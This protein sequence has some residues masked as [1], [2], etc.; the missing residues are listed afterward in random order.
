MQNLLENAIFS[1]EMATFEESGKNTCLWMLQHPEFNI[2][3]FRLLG[4]IESD[5]QIHFENYDPVG[6]N[7]RRLLREVAKK[8]DFPIYFAGYLTHNGTVRMDYRLRKD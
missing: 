7:L 6:K 2:I 4:E 3:I 1:N 8:Y 5:L